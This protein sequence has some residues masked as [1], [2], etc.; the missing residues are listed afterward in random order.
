MATSRSRIIRFGIVA[1]GL[2]ATVRGWQGRA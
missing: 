1:L 2:L